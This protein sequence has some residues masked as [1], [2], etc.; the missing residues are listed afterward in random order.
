MI[1]TVLIDDEPLALNELRF[2]LNKVAQIEIVNSYTNPLTALEQL[3]KDKPA[4]V[5]LDIDMPEISGICLA[6]EILHIHKNISVVFVTAHNEYAV[7]AF[8]INAVDYI[9]KPVSFERLR[10]CIKKILAKSG[11]NLS[12]SVLDKIRNA[13]VNQNRYQKIVISE[14]NEIHI[15]DP[16]EVLYFSSEQGNT[17]AVTKHGRHKTKDS[18]DFWENSLAGKGFFRCHRSFMVN[19]NRIKKISSWFGNTY[20]I[21]LDRT[22]EN[23]PVSKR[24]VKEFDGN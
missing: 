21:K 6:Q 18:L 20:S 12:D 7:K 1:R 4:L 24:K 23:I 16:E 3:N 10:L 22:D 13:A 8:E 5:F 9:L 2:L 14:D 17:I 11:S 19:I 15:Y